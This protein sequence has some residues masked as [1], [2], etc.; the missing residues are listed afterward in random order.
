MAA[1]TLF[2]IWN[3]I[4][5]CATRAVSAFSPSI[6]NTTG[7]WYNAINKTALGRLTTRAFW[8]FIDSYSAWCSGYSANEHFEKLRPEPRGMG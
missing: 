3:I 1:P 4:D 2:G 8:G 7:V 5:V 6:W